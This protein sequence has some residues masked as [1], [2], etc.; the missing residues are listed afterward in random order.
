M[1]PEKNKNLSM[2]RFCDLSGGA[3]LGGVYLSEGISPAAMESR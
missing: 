2:S 1:E 3:V